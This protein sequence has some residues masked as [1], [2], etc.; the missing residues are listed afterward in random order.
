M[1]WAKY[2]QWEVDHIVPLSRARTLAEAI[3]LCHYTNL[4]PLWKRENIIKGGA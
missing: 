1:T 4:Q 3:R 2:G